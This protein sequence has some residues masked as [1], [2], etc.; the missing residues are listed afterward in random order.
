MVPTNAYEPHSARL[1]WRKS[2][3][4]VGNG[5]CVEVACA[6]GWVFVHDSKL[7]AGPVLFFTAKAWRY[8][9][10]TIKSFDFDVF[11]TPRIK[12]C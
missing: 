3:Y 12:T 5:E 10:A 2:S 4:S 8:F 7:S 9:I 6:L 11:P 1:Q